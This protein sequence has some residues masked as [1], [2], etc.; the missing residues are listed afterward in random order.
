MKKYENQIPTDMSMGPKKIF[1]LLRD[2]LLV[3]SKLK[4]SANIDV[5]DFRLS[6]EP[7]ASDAACV[8]WFGHSAFLLELEGKRLLFDPMLGPR[9][10]WA[11]AR[12][13]SKQLLLPVD[14]F[15][16]V[17]AVLLSHDHYDHLDVFSIRKLKDKARRFLVPSGVSRHLVKCGVAPDKISEHRW[18]E[19]LAI[20][21]ITLACLPARHFS[22]RG[23]FNRNCTLWC[24]WTIIGRKTRVYF[25]GDSGYGPHFKEIGEMYGP[26]D[27]TMLECGQYDER[28]L[29]HMKPE[30]T[31]QAHL[32]L[33]GGLLI[34]VHWGAFTLAFHSWTDPI[35]RVTKEASERRVHIA[36]PRIGETVA[37]ADKENRGGAWWRI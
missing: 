35:E 9:V 2:T 19:E 36:T 27:L 22:G 28:W 11:G 25:S 32:D 31:V 30:E 34:P 3:R 8:T 29:I 7:A 17:D 15:P 20:D 6:G 37:I 1:S 12:R 14:D 23:L 24:S 26:F 18:Y 33:R 13:Y 16:T 10:P 4:P 21:D 5:V